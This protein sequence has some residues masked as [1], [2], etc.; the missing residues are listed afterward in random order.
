MPYLARLAGCAWRRRYVILL[1]ILLGMLVTALDA[2][3]QDEKRVLKHELDQHTIYIVLVQL[4]RQVTLL[5][6][7]RRDGSE[8]SM[9]PSV[10]TLTQAGIKFKS[11]R[12][13]KMDRVEGG[14]EIRFP[15]ETSVTYKVTKVDPQVL[16][17]GTQGT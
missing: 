7:W 3:A 2:Y 10:V 11:G 17:I 4:D 12:A 15:D 16:C 6:V 9:Y 14:I 5:E 8:C 1:A 13:W